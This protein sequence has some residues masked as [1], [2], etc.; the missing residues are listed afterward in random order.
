MLYGRVR[1]HLR[2]NVSMEVKEGAGVPNSKLPRTEMGPRRE[3]H[4]RKIILAYSDEHCYREVATC[5]EDA[6]ASRQ[7]DRPAPFAVL[8]LAALPQGDFIREVGRAYRM[9]A[10]SATTCTPIPLRTSGFDREQGLSEASAP[11]SRT[12]GSQSG[13]RFSTGIRKNKHK[14]SPRRDRRE[15]FCL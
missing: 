10:E 9:S 8:Q 14:A 1:S 11:C 6:T 4:P 3:L 5:F 12:R 15:E 13:L 7:I 2:R